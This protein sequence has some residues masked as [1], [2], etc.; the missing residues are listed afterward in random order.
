MNDS[1]DRVSTVVHVLPSA[2]PCRTQSRGSRSGASLA[3]VRA[4]LTT[5]AGASRVYCA[6]LVGVLVSHLV[7]GSPSLR[8][9]PFSL[10]FGW[11]LTAMAVTC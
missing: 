5:V 9:L 10:A 3:E 8:L 2:E 7:A 6:Q 11:A 4:Y 1:P